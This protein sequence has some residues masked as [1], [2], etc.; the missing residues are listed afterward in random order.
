MTDAPRLEA[1]FARI[2]VEVAALRRSAER[3]DATLYAEADA[4]PAVKYRLVVAIEAAVD[5]AEHIVAAEGLR[6]STSMADV[7]RSLAEAGWLPTDLGQLLEDAARF[8]NLLVHQYG[9]VDDER[10]IAIL[11]TRLDDLDRFVTV[12]AGRLT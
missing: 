10:V 8:R 12:L 1:L 4:L 5:A 11:R 7:F 3:D 2:G 9:D 6:S